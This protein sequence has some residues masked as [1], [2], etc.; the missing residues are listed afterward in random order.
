[1]SLDK[2][3]NKI[4]G[5]K[6][7][8]I[9]DVMLDSYSFGKIERNSP[10]AP[11]PIVDVINKEN[12]IGGAANV[13]LNIKSL[14]GIPY[15]FS[16]IGDD[17]YGKIFLDLLEK[18]K[19]STDYIIIDPKRKTTVKERIIVKKNHVLR[20]DDE[21][22]NNLSKI[23]QEKLIE[24]MIKL[25]KKCDLLIIQDYEKGLLN[26]NFINDIIKNLKN[27]ITIAVDPKFKNF[28]FYNNIDLFKP[29]L[30]ESCKGF[31]LNIKTISTK[32][33][34]LVAQKYL[35]KNK[36]KFIMIT[37]SENGILIV[38]KKSIS[39][40]KIKSKNIVDVSGAGDTV[41]AIASLCIYLSTSIPF[42][43]N[44]SNLAGKIVCQSSGVVPI[45]KSKLY[46]EAKENEL[47]K[48]A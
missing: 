28:K 7:I 40:F 3:F 18:K 23:L 33:I 47:I 11:V 4:N 26:K 2:F 1:M 24:K 16:C 44:I 34:G 46:N 8:I 37:M 14:G 27:K 15:L 38:D 10:E 29:N 20:V 48:E 31:N 12:R 45:S 13:A 35:I 32:K 22:T 41:I 19:I 17:H 9:G 42:L 36:I 21:N 25:S 5:L 30:I 43:C 39:H 6:V